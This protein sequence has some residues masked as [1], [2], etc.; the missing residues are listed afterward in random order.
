MTLSGFDSGLGE[1]VAFTCQACSRIELFGRA[2]V[3]EADLRGISSD[4]NR[5]GTQIPAE[6]AQCPN[7]SEPKEAP[8]VLKGRGV[9]GRPVASLHVDSG[10]PRVN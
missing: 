3:T 9:V 6:M 7:C 1:G 2:R 8:G 10:A 4:C 5:C